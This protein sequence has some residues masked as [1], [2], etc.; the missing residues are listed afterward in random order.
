MAEVGHI[1]IL[2][3]KVSIR[4][5]LASSCLHAVVLVTLGLVCLMTLPMFDD[6]WSPSIV[7]R[8]AK[9]LLGVL[10]MPMWALLNLGYGDSEIPLGV[11]LTALA[12]N[13]LVWGVALA[14]LRA[15]WLRREQA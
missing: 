5:V 10:V 7:G 11:E 6:D 1:V 4:Q 15:W 9:V 8:V 2:V 14:C 12:L 3:R 13:S